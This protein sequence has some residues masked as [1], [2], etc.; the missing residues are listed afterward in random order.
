M[1]V[2]DLTYNFSIDQKEKSRLVICQGFRFDG[3]EMLVD[4]L[5]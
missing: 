4:T 2:T 1:K 3:Q 5:G